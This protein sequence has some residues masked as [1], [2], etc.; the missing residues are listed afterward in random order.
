MIRRPPRSTLSSSSAASDVYKRQ[1]F[2]EHRSNPVRMQDR[3]PYLW[4][5][6]VAKLKSTLSTP[7]F[8][9]E[10]V[11]GEYFTFQV[12]IF[13]PEAQEVLQDVGIGFKGFPGEIAATMTC[14]NTGGIDAQGNTFVT[15][16]DVL[17]G[18]IKSF[19]IGFSV[20]ATLAVGST[21]TGK[22][23]LSPPS[24]TTSTV[25]TTT[26]VQVALTVSSAAA[27]VDP[28]VMDS[29]PANYTRLRWLN[30]NLAQDDR[31]VTPFSPVTISRTSPGSQVEFG[32]LNRNLTIGANGLMDRILSLIHISEP[33]R[34]LSISYAVFCLKKKKINT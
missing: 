7:M 10:V 18:S 27:I 31:V 11:R 12:A 14:F 2:T 34:L 16:V 21:V 3:L 15:R 33:T 1:V 22:V 5:E 23:V 17:P 26:D 24:A 25:A 4:V 29:D 6:R 9:S 19:W 20:P 8:A 32:V 30:S 13:V 28:A